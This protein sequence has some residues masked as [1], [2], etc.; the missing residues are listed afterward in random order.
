MQK[1]TSVI[2]IYHKRF[3]V[4][5]K[6]SYAIISCS[7]VIRQVQSQLNYTPSPLPYAGF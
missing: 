1:H 5:D 7:L 2:S 4:E 6:T 3:W